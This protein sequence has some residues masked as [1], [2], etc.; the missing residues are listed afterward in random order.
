MEQ[1]KLNQAKTVMRD[2]PS[3]P[4]EIEKHLS[5]RPNLTG[6]LCEFF[7]CNDKVLP[8]RIIGWKTIK[9]SKKP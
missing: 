9:G 3:D 6:L 4:D 2:L 5:A 7:Q 8:Y 1:E